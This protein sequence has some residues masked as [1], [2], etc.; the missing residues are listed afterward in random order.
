MISE[1]ILWITFLNEPE[2]FTYFYPILSIYLGGDLSTGNMRDK[3]S[4][5]IGIY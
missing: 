1:H 5:H 4:I 2:L 3:G